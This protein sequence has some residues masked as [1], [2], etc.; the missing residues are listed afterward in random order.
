MSR[1][2][3]QSIMVLCIQYSMYHAPSNSLYEVFLA[4]TRF[5]QTVNEGID[6]V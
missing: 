2:R 5:F 3:H 1:N 6:E 4:Y